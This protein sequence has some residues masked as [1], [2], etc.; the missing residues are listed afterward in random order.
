MSK[1]IFRWKNSIIQVKIINIIKFKLTVIGVLLLMLSICSCQSNALMQKTKLISDS[2]CDGG[3][4]VRNNEYMYYYKSRMGD[5]ECQDIYRYNINNCTEEYV[6]SSFA[7]DIKERCVFRLF[8][9]GNRVYYIK[10]ESGKSVIYSISNI[11]TK[12]FQEGIIDEDLYSVDLPEAS[13]YEYRMFKYDDLYVL[14]NR[15]LYRVNRDVSEIIAEGICSLAL[16]DNDVYYSKLLTRAENY[17]FNVY[18]SQTGGILC[19]NINTKENREI[20]SAEKIA[21]YNAA[22]VLGHTASVKNILVDNEGI[23][24]LGAEYVSPVLY[25]NKL[26]NG[27]I[28]NVSGSDSKT[29]Y[30]RMFRINDGKIFYRNQKGSV[31][32][33]D[34]EKQS[35]YKDLEHV[36]AFYPFGDLIYYYRLNDVNIPEIR[37]YNIP[38]KSDD[39]VIDMGII[40]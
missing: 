33:I 18:D 14:I 11:D 15:K 25:I 27:D 34:V 32:S 29:S 13:Y 28:I 4:F 10:K 22:T 3:Y 1:R 2:S 21:E 23:Y 9:I 31:Y 30:T 16:Y 6:D 24:F 8:S 38:V 17:D 40:E 26:G 20:I 36:N 19:Y 7:G 5:E 39:L 12:P 35:K 37:A